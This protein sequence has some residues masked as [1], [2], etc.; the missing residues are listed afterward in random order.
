MSI[1]LRL[2]ENIH[3]GTLSGTARVAV[4]DRGR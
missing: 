2:I 4:F 3:A 1:P